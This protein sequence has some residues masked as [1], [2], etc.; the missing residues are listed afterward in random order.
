MRIRAKELRQARKRRAD[1][2]KARIKAE[3]KAVKVSRTTKK[4]EA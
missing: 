2:Y 4:N 1:T 3:G